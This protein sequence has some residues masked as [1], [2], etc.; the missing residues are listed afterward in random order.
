M[1]VRISEPSKQAA[2][3]P[4]SQTNKR[5]HCTPTILVL[6]GWNSKRLCS[7]YAQRHHNHSIHN[8][9]RAS[10]QMYRQ[11]KAEGVT[12]AYSISL[13]FLHAYSKW[14]GAWVQINVV[15]NGAHCICLKHR[16]SNWSKNDLIFLGYR[17]HGACVW[18]DTIERWQ[19]ELHVHIVLNATIFS[20]LLYFY[21]MFL[22]LLLRPPFSSI[23]SGSQN[24]IVSFSLLFQCVTLN[25]SLFNI[26]NL[27]ILTNSESL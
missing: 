7:V 11:S 5:L 22:L 27:K 26:N 18:L 9:R 20:V 24:V 3:Q 16:L 21:H 14:I 2:K 12:H 23:S 25:V 15:K 19:C 4:S 6:V 17:L 1:C 13:T 10:S 8:I